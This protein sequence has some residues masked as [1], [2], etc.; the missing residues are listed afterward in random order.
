M[1]MIAKAMEVMRTESLMP[2]PGVWVRS[3]YFMSKDSP[4]G[5]VLVRYHLDKNGTCYFHHGIYVGDSKIAHFQK[6]ATAPSL[7]PVSEFVTGNWFVVVNYPDYTAELRQTAIRT[8]HFFVQHPG[9]LGHY[10]VCTN[11][12]ECFV[13]LCI[14]G[15]PRSEQVTKIMTAAWAARPSAADVERV[16][17]VSF[18]SCVV[19]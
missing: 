17:A 7:T 5:Q 2:S 14:T 12:C 8:A 19:S 15:E 10:N 13:T 3:V 4:E 6:G 18:A 9:A 11:N 16:V 1:D